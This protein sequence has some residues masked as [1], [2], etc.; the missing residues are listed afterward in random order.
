VLLSIIIFGLVKVV[1]SG[2]RVID[3]MALRLFGAS[4]VVE[5]AG[6]LAMP[7]FADHPYVSVEVVGRSLSHG[8]MV[9]AAIRQR[10]AASLTSED[11][12][13][14]DRRPFSVLPYFAVA[15]VNGL[16]LVT[17]RG[18]HAAPLVVGTA[19]ATLTGLV[20]ARQLGAFRD[21]S[22]LLAELRLQERRF[23]S[24]VQNATDV[25]AICERDGTVT[26][27]SPGVQRL[28]GHWPEEMLGTRGPT[29]HPDDFAVIGASFHEIRTAPPGTTKTE[30]GRIGH[31][32]GSWR[33]AQ[34]TFTNLL[35]DPAVRGVVTNTSDI[36][37]AH[38]FHRE[39][40]H[41]ASHDPL[42]DLANRS[43]FGSRLELALARADGRQVSLALIDLDDFKPVND[44][45]GHHAGDALLIAVAER[46]GRGVRP[47][48]LVA[49][50]G[51]DEFA[52]LFD[53]AG[54][55][56]VEAIADRMLTVLAEPL[57]VD[58]HTL[59]VRAS[60]GIAA[61]QAGDDADGL[62]RRADLALY[63]AKDAGKGRCVRYTTTMRP[64]V[65]LPRRS[66]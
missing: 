10:R 8:V 15:A 39:L 6:V 20:T 3:P 17:L 5:I 12:D 49:R 50:L 7:L 64:K 48:D 27:I 36:S 41:Q 24:L 31:V 28:T 54:A 2:S 44:T 22:R 57:I 14:A 66:T 32:D 42:T 13:R 18:G 63:A 59:R 38:A 29:V 33:W 46:L 26:Y 37:E 30:Q 65:S 1:L 47:Q 45:L 62:M 35:D 34:I 4:L 25:T 11:R 43:L 52:V 60:V 56:I 55:S 23:R 9:A 16:L 53:G 40:T 19:A 58:G 61:A 51:G 21:N